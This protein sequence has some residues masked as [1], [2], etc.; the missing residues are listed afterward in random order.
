MLPHSRLVG[1]ESTRHVENRH[2]RVYLDEAIS[3][4]REK[5]KEI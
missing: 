3:V 4:L 1:V 5:W 2:G